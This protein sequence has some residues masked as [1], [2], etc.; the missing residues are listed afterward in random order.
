[1]AKKRIT[2]VIKVPKTE[3]PKVTENIKV[4]KVKEV[5][6]EKKPGQVRYNG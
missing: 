1:M 4:V 3:K 2:E 5:S 6:R